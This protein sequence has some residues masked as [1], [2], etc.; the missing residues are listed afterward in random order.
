MPYTLKKSGNKYYVEN[1]KTKYK[2]SKKPISK[3]KASRQKKILETIEKDGCFF[4]GLAFGKPFEIFGGTEAGT[5]KNQ[6][7][8]KWENL[9]DRDMECT[10]LVEC[11]KMIELA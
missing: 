11:F 10:S 4:R 3:D 1:T 6:W 7:F 2:H 8:V 9:G 5:N